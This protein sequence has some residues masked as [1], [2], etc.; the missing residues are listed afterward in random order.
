MDKSFK[1]Y[2]FEDLGSG[3]TFGRLGSL[4][5]VADRDQLSI[6]IFETGPQGISNDTLYLTLHKD[7]REWPKSFIQEIVFRIPDRE[8]KGFHLDMYLVNFEDGRLVFFVRA[9]QDN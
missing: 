6:D 7:R 8:F 1:A 5:A 4:H 9:D 2:V 3:L